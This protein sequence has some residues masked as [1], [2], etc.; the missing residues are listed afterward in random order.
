MKNF[1]TNKHVIAAMIVT[2]ILAVLSYTLVDRLVAEKPHVAQAGSSY[3]LIAQSNCR[4]TSGQCDLKN[5]DFKVSLSIDTQDGR[6][7]LNLVSSH[8]IDGAVAGFEYADQA[9][10]AA[11]QPNSM[12]MLDAPTRWQIGA[13][14]TVDKNTKVMLVLHSAGVK[15]FAE[16]TM[17]FSKLETSFNK[18]F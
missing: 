11:A 3:P 12:T 18:T 15:Y 16:T 9:T 8:P 5:S 17:A 10:S 1:F 4:F 6:N 13:P 7:Q 14:D 2:P